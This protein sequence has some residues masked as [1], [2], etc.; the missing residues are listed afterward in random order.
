MGTAWTDIERTTAAA[1]VAAGTTRI[2]DVLHLFP[3][4]TK[5]HVWNMLA[6]AKRKA[7]GKCNCGSP[8][9]AEA[10]VARRLCPK[11]RARS[12]VAHAKHLATGMC[13]RCRKR[14]AN[15]SLTQCAECLEARRAAA[16]RKETSRTSSVNDYAWSGLVRW[17]ASLWPQAV[18][19]HIPEDGTLLVDLFGGSAAV[20]LA[21]CETGNM[22]VVFNDVHPTLC[23]LVDV[24]RLGRVKDLV[25][26]SQALG[27]L[28][29]TELLTHYEQRGDLSKV[30]R[31]AAL[32]T[33][34]QSVTRRD[35]FRKEIPS[36][37][38]IRASYGVRL[39]KA[40]ATMKNLQVRNLDF[41]DALDAYDS[42]QTLFFVDP[43]YPNTSFYE[44]NLT[45]DRFAEL[46]ERLAKIRGRFLLT[47]S[48][49]R[50]SAVACSHLPYL[51]RLL[52]HHGLTKSHL[53]VASNYP[54]KLPRIDLAAFGI[55]SRS[56]G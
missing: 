39:A 49:S 35:L 18:L 30:E 33:V 48:S 1:L 51:W 40:S 12:R 38:P 54:L 10:L 53:L 5:Q 27:K 22:D 28:S 43:P 42:P 4:R 52:H 26:A 23:D 24:V 14:P 20:S 46:T 56:D 25:G 47:T 6:V 9:T 17:R 3:G 55:R 31:A 2:K 32:L 37:H 7:A 16:A 8:L 45:P 50:V 15:A 36:V 13:I 34:A 19:R 29:P 44:H 11:C 21:A 41:A